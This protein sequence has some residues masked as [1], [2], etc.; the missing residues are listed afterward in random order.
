MI[1]ENKLIEI[2]Y[3]YTKQKRELLLSIGIIDKFDQYKICFGENGRICE[4]SNFSYE[5]GSI[6]K[7]VVA[8]LVVN[9]IEQNVIQLSDPIWKDITLKQLLTHEFRIAE[10]PIP[11][12][13]VPNPFS[14]I[15]KKD[16]KE[17]IKEASIHKTSNWSYSNLGFALI[18]MYLEKKLNKDFSEIFE[19]YIDKTLKLRN[20][21]IGYEGSD[22][23]G[24]NETSTL[25]WFWNRKSVF[26]PAGS[27]VSTVD[28]M[29]EY[30]KLHMR[31]D[32]FS[33]CHKIHFETDMPFNMGLAFMKQKEDDVTFCA[34]LTPGFSSV[35]GFDSS[36]H[37]GVVVL[38]NYCG[39][40]YGNPNIPMGIGF[41]ILNE[42][43]KDT[44]K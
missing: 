38:S 9:L 19:E 31:N 12:R 17:F 32:A 8:S 4:T 21:H 39:Y 24:H 41:S 13:D 23:Y 33:L 7:S 29:M 35:I 16:V 28:D 37:F 5:I 43:G 34:G 1:S 30:L 11:D 10:F 26:L 18:G 15:F 6:T 44:S 2:V 36:K 27:L 42:L 22:L 25:K 40:G 3:P 20:T 14:D